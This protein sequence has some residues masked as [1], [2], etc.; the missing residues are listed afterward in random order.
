MSESLLWIS[1]EQEALISD[2]AKYNSKLR[3]PEEGRTS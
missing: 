2:L 1:Q 3:R